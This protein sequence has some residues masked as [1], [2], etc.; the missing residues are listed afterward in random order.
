[1]TPADPTAS[2]QIVDTVQALR[3]RADAAERRVRALLRDQDQI[4]QNNVTLQHRVAAL[5]N[6]NAQL[7]ADLVRVQGSLDLA[8][9]ELVDIEGALQRPPAIGLQSAIEA[10]LG[11]WRTRDGNLVRVSEMAHQ[12]IVNARAHVD[13]K[14]CPSHDE[15]E[16]C[17][18]C[19]TVDAFRRVWLRIFD[20][21]I[22]RRAQQ[23]PSTSREFL[24]KAED[25]PATTADKVL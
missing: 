10:T 23:P 9:G 1:M 20:E 5:T 4:L 22:A 7:R 18:A 8:V 6:E 2:Q 15:C 13:A 12:H 14:R 17:C 11:L 25:A 21:E 24:H 16:P 3:G 19:V